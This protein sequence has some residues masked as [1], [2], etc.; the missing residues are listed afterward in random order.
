MD[1]RTKRVFGSKGEGKG[2]RKDIKEQKTKS[3]DLLVSIILSKG[4]LNVL[5]PEPSPL[6]T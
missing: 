3:L 4:N 5:P 1:C 2:F 6:Q